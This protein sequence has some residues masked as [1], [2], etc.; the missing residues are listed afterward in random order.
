M[1]C[2]NM[3]RLEKERVWTYSADVA[4]FSVYE[5]GVKDRDGASGHGGCVV[6]ICEGDD[7]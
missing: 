7:R 1:V 4:P 5:R 3:V 6:P 2:Q